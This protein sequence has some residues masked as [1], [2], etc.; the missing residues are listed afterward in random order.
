M[1]Q[2]LYLGKD[3]FFI[4]LSKDKYNLAQKFAGRNTNPIISNTSLR[5]S[6]MYAFKITESSFKVSKNGKRGDNYGCKHGEPN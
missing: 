1:V 3:I 6:K 2:A 4:F 5:F